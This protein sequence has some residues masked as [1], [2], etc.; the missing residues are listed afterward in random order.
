MVGED[1]KRK[2]ETS[3]AGVGKR[4]VD[5]FVRRCYRLNADAV[6]RMLLK[7]QPHLRESGITTV[8]D[9]RQYRE[10]IGFEF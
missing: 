6:D 9:L 1:K 10:E 5:A 4:S 8:E 7:D 2:A 3:D